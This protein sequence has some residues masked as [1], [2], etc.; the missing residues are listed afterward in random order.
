MAMALLSSRWLSRLAPAVGALALAVLAS[1]AGADEEEEKRRLSALGA[2]MLEVADKVDRVGRDEL[3]AEAFPLVAQ[4]ELLD[5]HGLFKPPRRGGLDVGLPPVGAGPDG[6]EIRLIRLT[7]KPLTA[8]ELNRDRP[9]L[10]RMAQATVAVAHATALYPRPRLKP[11]DWDQALDEM[12][13]ASAG[14]LEAT[15]G[16]NPAAVRTAAV[17]LNNNCMDCHS[18]YR[19]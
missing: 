10:F 8:A 15:R 7:R 16:G 9:A 19:E 13:T 2:R 1:P 4:A 14:F 3:E 6:I 12:R 5:L 11:R 17:R 18:V